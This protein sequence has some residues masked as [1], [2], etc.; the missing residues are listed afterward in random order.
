MY[1][2]RNTAI[3]PT[4]IFSPRVAVVLPRNRIWLWHR[5]AILR[6]TKF[7]N[8]DLYYSD[9]VTP[10][11]RSIRYWLAFEHKLLARDTILQSRAIEKEGRPDFELKQKQ[12]EYDVILNLSEEP[13]LRPDGRILELRYN[14]SLN[15]K[16]LF[17][18]LMTQQSP[19]FAVYDGFNQL[20][21]STSQVNVPDK[22]VLSRGLDAAFCR[23]AALVER[24]VRHVVGGTSEAVPAP[25]R[26]KHIDL[27]WKVMVRYFSSFF[28]NKTGKRILRRFQ[29][30]E[31]WSIAILHDY[32]VDVSDF[33]KMDVFARHKGVVIDNK[34]DQ[35]FADPFL[36]DYDGKT[37]LFMESISR[38]TNKGSISCAQ[39]GADDQISAA[40]IILEKPYHLSY[41]FVFEHEDRV[42][43]IPET[44]ENR[45]V[46]LY[47]SERFPYEWKLFKVLL[48]NISIYDV[49]LVRHNSKWWLFGA[50]GSDSLLPQ[51]ELAIFFSDNV[52]GPWAINVIAEKDF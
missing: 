40:E 28:W 43:M 44:G 34:N 42:F 17:A 46:E 16:S 20:S 26:Y 51:D 52:E 25:L 1:P 14:G 4:E 2:S 38:K 30:Q 31:Y 18:S 9:R 29:I 3:V 48:S 8:I 5:H 10:Y 36:F 49:T 24:A 7:A 45:S 15:S 32:K 21:V 35:H 22:I 12:K 37:W 23:L 41:P 27:S 33:S 39:L 6:L 50:S 11:R 47:V 19:H 13:L